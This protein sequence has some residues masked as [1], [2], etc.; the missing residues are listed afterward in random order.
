MR[1]C[2]QELADELQSS[3][4]KIYPV[5]C[6]LTRE[7]DILKA[8]EWIETTV[9]EGVSVLVNNAGI[10]TTS[11]LLGEYRYLYDH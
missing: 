4:A 11:K 3:V 7:S 10:L 9:G 8:F 2:I 1:L 5:Q 6:D